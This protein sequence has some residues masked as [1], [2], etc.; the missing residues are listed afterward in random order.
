MSIKTRKIFAAFVAVLCAFAAF[1]A[2]MG[3]ASARRRRRKDG[4]VPVYEL[5]GSDDFEGLK[6][7]EEGKSQYIWDNTAMFYAENETASVTTAGGGGPRGRRLAQV[8]PRTR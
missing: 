6:P 7:V 5:A 4:Y 2:A 8:V 3:V 1:A